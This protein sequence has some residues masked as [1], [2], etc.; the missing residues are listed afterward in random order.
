MCRRDIEKFRQIEEDRKQ[1]IREEKEKEQKRIFDAAA[2]LQRI[3]RGKIYRSR[4]RVLMCEEMY[5]RAFGIR[6][7]AAIRKATA[8]HAL[9]G[10]SSKMIKY[11]HMNA[12]ELLLEVMNEMWIR[13]QLDDAIKGGCLELLQDAV[14][15]T[16][17]DS[18]ML[19]VL[20]L[21]NLTARVAPTMNVDPALFG[22]V[23]FGFVLFCLVSFQTLLY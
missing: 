23:L 1:K 13:T 11:Y 10:V 8:M 15:V 3:V 12:R 22:F 16:K 17:R 2:K 5:K 7:E 20:F 14:K 9:F 19:L 6:E 4:G 21:T 18:R